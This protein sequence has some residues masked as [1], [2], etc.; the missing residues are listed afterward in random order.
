MEHCFVKSSLFKIQT[1]THVVSAN[2]IINSMEGK[3]DFHA[4]Q[5]VHSC[6]RYISK[7]D[8]SKR[9]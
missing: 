7:E 5:S 8:Q 3:K 2:Q 6:C 9:I 1:R 4:S